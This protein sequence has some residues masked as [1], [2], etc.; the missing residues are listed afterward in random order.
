M[1]TTT[2]RILLANDVILQLRSGAFVPTKGVL[3]SERTRDKFR[4]KVQNPDDGKELQAVANTIKCEAC[5]NGCLFM[6]HIQRF[7]GVDLNKL[8]SV[9]HSNIENNS[10]IGSL[11]G[12]LLNEIEA[13]FEGEEFSWHRNFSDDEI[14]KMKAWRNKVLGVNYKFVRSWENGPGRRLTA[15]QRITLLTAIMELLIQNDGTK[16]LV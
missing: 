6:A 2:K 8:R 14:E 7:D 3:L 16:V 15:A 1:K 11:F 13:L 4:N 9:H 10:P 5:A 12:D